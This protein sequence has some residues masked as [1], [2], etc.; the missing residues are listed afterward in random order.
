MPPTILLADDDAAIC[1]F[2]AELLTVQGME[3][4]TAGDG[5]AA[6]EAFASRQP[7]LVLLDIRMPRLNGLEVCRWV[8]SNPESPHVERPKAC[9]QGWKATLDGSG[10]GSEGLFYVV[11]EHARRAPGQ[12]VL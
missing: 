6:L 12:G 2:L 10:C 7:D 3:V 11:V 9:A 4:V 5:I 1:E 8:K